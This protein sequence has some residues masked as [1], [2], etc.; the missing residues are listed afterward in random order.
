MGAR[1]ATEDL[2]I[3]DLLTLQTV[4]RRSSITGAAREMNVTPSQ[5]SK[6]I[7]RLERQLHATLIVR[8]SHGVTLS[9]AYRRMASHVDA[10]IEQWKALR[11]GDGDAVPELTIAAP[12]YLNLRFFPAIAASIGTS[13]LR[14]LE[15]PPAMVRAFVGESLFDAALT[16][17]AERLPKSWV[18][19]YA[20]ELRR[21]L[22][23]SPALARKLGP[24]PIDPS[25]LSSFPFVS[26]VYNANGR[27]MP[28]DDACPL[29]RA[30]RRL[31][32]E[33]ETIALALEVA[34]HTGQLVFGPSIAATTMV[35]SGA[36]VEIPVRGW[37]VTGSLYLAC[38]GDRMLK[39]TQRAI[40]SAVQRVLVASGE[41]AASAASGA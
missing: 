5:V 2:R 40:L 37:N 23:A 31:G 18:N 21:C 4:A 41:T 1:R 22:F 39:S 32:H 16:L 20:G 10:L 13:R 33:V 34:A 12:S 7:G 24:T 11:G 25:R 35:Q 28:S 3:A 6:A 17:G 26:P 29:N 38:D 36:L 15:M 27:L 19:V 8:S 9:D 30:E 14:S